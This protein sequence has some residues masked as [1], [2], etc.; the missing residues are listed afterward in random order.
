MNRFDVP[1]LHGDFKHPRNF[2]KVSGV[3]G[4][5]LVLI[6]LLVPTLVAC[7]DATNT[8]GSPTTAA[9]STTTVSS[10][11]TNTTTTAATM[12][13]PG[14]VTTTTVA[15]SPTTAAPNSGISA[16]PVAAVTPIGSATANVASNGS[17]TTIAP[18]GN[19]ETDIR[20]V[21]DAVK[22]AVVLIAVT[23]PQAQGVGTGSI[24][25]PDGFIVTNFHVV[26]A[27]TASVSPQT[28]IQVV[29]TD[30]KKYPAKVVGTDR[31]ND[32]AVVKIDAT[33]LPVIKQGSSSALHV[34]DW[35]IAVGNALGLPGGPTVTAGIVSAVGRSIQEPAPA[36]ANL[37]DLIQT[38]AAINPGNS[39]GP[40]LNLN[41]ELV[42]INTAA[43]VDPQ[44]GAAAQG[45]GFAI[46]VDQAKPIIQTLMSGTPI[47]P[48]YMGILPETLTPG[49]AARF[50]LP[51]STGVLIGQVGP[52][53]PAAQAGWKA[54]DTL[55][56]M[57]STKLTSV[58]DLQ[59]VLNKHKP[60]D[61]VSATL[62]TP[63][64]QTQQTRITF[65]QPPAQ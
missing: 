9:S 46:S 59:G 26:A 10:N 1:R 48:P 49:I 25:T 62:V 6:C 39:G 35:V 42:G 61:T 52:N 17:T 4:L 45:I 58:A 27:E 43:P 37:T 50:N 28:T 54:G 23:T 16:Q 2:R 22:P 47:V 7:G 14:A 30:G 41:G 34:G 55:T 57:D 29:M 18:S 38:N 19:L 33:G 40:L 56:E 44:S 31:T 36:S 8:A 13:S 51:I 24:I 5:I 21:V 60:G 20:A 64:G 3:S 11:A 53:T 65:G 63:Q 15:G 32:L 12:S